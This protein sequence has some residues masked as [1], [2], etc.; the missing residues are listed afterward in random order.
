MDKSTLKKH[1]IPLILPLNAKIIVTLE[2]SKEYEVVCTFYFSKNGKH[3]E[4]IPFMEGE[5]TLHRHSHERIFKIC[6]MRAL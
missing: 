3:H 5:Y 1:K 2:T 6:E 4:F